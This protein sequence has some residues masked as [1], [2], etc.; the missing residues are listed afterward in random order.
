MQSCLFYLEDWK[1]DVWAHYLFG[2]FFLVAPFLM[3]ADE[4]FKISKLEN[5]NVIPQ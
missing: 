5:E 4:E 2:V 1:T 3:E